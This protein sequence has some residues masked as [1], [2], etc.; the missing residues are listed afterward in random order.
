VQLRATAGLAPWFVA[1]AVVALVGGFVDPDLR[2]WVW[3]ASLAIDIA[4]TLVAGRTRWKVSP[5]HF[6]ERY[7][8]IVIIALGESVVAIGLGVRELERDGVFAL[9]VLIALAGVVALWWAYFDFT[10]VA[11]ERA[12]ARATPAARG[13]IA[14][15][16]F[17]YFHFPIVLGVVFYAVAAEKTLAHPTDPLSQAGR[18]ALGLGVAF[19]LLGF[20]L[21]RWR[22]IR[23]VAW[24]RVAAGVTAIAAAVALDRSDALV[25]LA[26][27]LAI[28]AAALTVETVRLREVRAGLRSA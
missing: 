15:D 6:A 1:A 26:L 13:T 10:A 28:L 16:V 24:E 9:S 17:T 27:V 2:P 4:G 23:R 3:L 19:F 8:L 7:G 21:Q 12:L 20:A 14:R 5:A 18:W 22:V 25:T 11:A